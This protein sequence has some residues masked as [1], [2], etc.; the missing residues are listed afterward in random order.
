MMFDRGVDGFCPWCGAGYSA[1]DTLLLF[2]F[3]LLVIAGVVMLV[4]WLVR[5]TGNSGNRS[6]GAASSSED[7]AVHI[8][9]ERFARGEI[10]KDEYEEIVR[11]LGS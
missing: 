9:R 10:S 11:G 4:V 2:L 6:A 3:G 1:T 5:T 8:A 7:P